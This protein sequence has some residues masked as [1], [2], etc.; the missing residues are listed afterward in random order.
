MTQRHLTTTKWTPMAIESL[1][2]RG[3]LKD[4]REFAQALRNDASLVATANRVADRH[5]D[6]GTVAIY[7]ILVEDLVAAAN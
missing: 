4:W 2:E 5:E 3:V 6:R 1:S 7:R